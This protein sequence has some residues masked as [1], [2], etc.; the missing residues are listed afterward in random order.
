M[1]HLSL[2]VADT[3]A[4]FA[5]LRTEADALRDQFI[6]TDIDISDDVFGQAHVAETQRL[7]AALAR[8]HS[9]NVALA[10]GLSDVSSSGIEHVAAFS[11]TEAHNN[12]SIAA[13]IADETEG[14]K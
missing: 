6:A 5:A 8:L 11:V 4:E 13:V 1:N 2:N 7:K 9:R 10:Q 12:R 14:G 3:L